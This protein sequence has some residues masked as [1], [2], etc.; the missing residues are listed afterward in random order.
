MFIIS[1]FLWSY[2]T[3]SKYQKNNKESYF[4]TRSEWVFYFLSKRKLKVVYECHQLSK[5]KKTLIKR[6][7]QNKDSRIVFLNPDMLKDLAIDESKNIIILPSAYDEN[8]FHNTKAKP[9]NTRIVYAG[10]LFRFGQ[11]RGLG[12]FAEHLNK[13]SNLDIELVIATTDSKSYKFI[14]QIKKNN[15]N[16]RFELYSNLSRGQVSEL[17]NNCSIGLLVNND[18]IHATKFTSPLKFFEYVATGLKV[19]ATDNK[20]HK[21]LPYQ[22]NIYFFDLNSSDSIEKAIKNSIESPFPNYHNIHHYSM[23]NRISKLIKLFQ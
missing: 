1:H 4:F 18:S 8:I 23:D 13:I 20:A 10:S 2:F 3:V 14:E 17:Y 11:P 9:K 7:I 15:K 12:L 19:I 16:I 5:I 22:D 6:C 21:L